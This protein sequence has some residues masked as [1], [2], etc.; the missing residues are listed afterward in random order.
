M[1]KRAAGQPVPASSL[2]SEQVL[3]LLAETPPYIAAITAG[4]TAAQLQAIPGPDQW[5]AND[6]LAHL[7]S[8]ADVWGDCIT[9]L[10]EQ[11]APTLRAVSPRAWIQKTNYREQQFRRS[12][13]AFAAQRADLLTV[14]EPL[15][16]RAWSRTATVTGAGKR[17]TSTV[18]SYAQRLA[19]HERRHLEQFARIATG[20]RA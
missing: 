18:L 5:S 17:L 13:R 15:S 8:C 20:M 4:L 16:P 11:D 9:T 7:R 1:R 12:L 19:V 6:V 10:L 3:T 2:T 14:L